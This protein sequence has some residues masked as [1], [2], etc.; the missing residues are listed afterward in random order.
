MKRQLPTEAEYAKAAELRLAL[1]KFLRRS[2]EVTRAHG[3]TPH[4][5]QLLL[6]IRASNGRAT[7]GGLAAALQ[8]GQSNVTQRIRRLEN[9][10]LVR[11]ELSKED[12]RV[13]YLRLTAKGDRRLAGA[14]A[15]LA[16]DRDELVA[17]LSGLRA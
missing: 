8:L 1:R 9:A 16:E 13:R 4:R 14:V 10:G 17:I 15:E 5:Y 2:E 3:L 6:Q 11:R 12:A 7:V